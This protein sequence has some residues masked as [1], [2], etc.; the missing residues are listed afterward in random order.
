MVVQQT[1][2]HPTASLLI[3]LQL[4]GEVGCDGGCEVISVDAEEETR[5]VHVGR[6][7]AA[8]QPDP[9]AAS[10]PGNTAGH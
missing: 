8:V 2:P 5:M 10:W 4:L 6:G 3:S 1:I 9:A 7:S